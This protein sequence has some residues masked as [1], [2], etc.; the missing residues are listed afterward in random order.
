L[1]LGKERSQRRSEKHLQPFRENVYKCT[2][3]GICKEVCSLN[4]D[5]IELC[6]ASRAELVQME[7]VFL[8]KH[9]VINERVS[10]KHN[11]YGEDPTARLSWLTSDT[12]ISSKGELAY[13]TGCT[14]A[15][16]QKEIATMTVNVLNRLG[17]TPVVLGAE[18]RC[19]GS[20][21]IRTGQ[22]NL[23]EGLV[24]H[25]VKELESRGVKRV[26]SSCAGCYRTMLMDWPKYYGK[27]LP[28]ETVHIAEYLAE[29]I[30]KGK[31]KFAGRLNETLTY[32][33]PCHLG[34]HAKVYEAPRKLIESF[35]G[36]RFV[37]MN[38]TKNYSRCC[39]AGGGVKSGY[40]DL[41]VD[42]AKVRVKDAM[43]VNANI[44]ASTCPFCTLNLKD[45][46][47]AAN[48]PIKTLDLVQLV[49]DL[50]IVKHF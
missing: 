4:L 31:L 3:C 6:E 28:F 8:T 38:L 11:P 42:M 45:G 10:E 41:A 17:R 20:P 27:P 14:A 32:H 21:L 26:V 18:E 49:N 46:I 9:K 47:K 2:T 50:N 22:T 29:E 34:R 36:V 33:D 24:R 5:T 7:G 16:R 40:N 35:P 25:N 30:D 44:L 1:I 12:K 19:C 15:L 23:I 37:E 39:G 48:A 43:E 13:F